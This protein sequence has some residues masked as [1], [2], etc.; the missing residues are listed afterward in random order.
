[1]LTRHCAPVLIA[2]LA[3]TASLTACGGAQSRYES[4]MKR[5]QAYFT[6]GD[7]TKASIEYRNALQVEP[8]SDAARLAVGRTAE[9]LQRPRDAYGLYQ[10][11]IDTSPDNLEAREDMARLLV[12][13]RSPD[14]AVKTLEP[15][16]A[17]HPDDPVLLTLRAAAR[18]Q[19]NNPAGAVADADRALQLAPLNEEA[20]E[21]RSGLY[22]QAGDIAGAKAL[23]ENAVHKLPASGQLREI[24]ADLDLAGNDAAAA[25]QQLTELIKLFPQETRYRFQ[26]AVVYSRNH[27]LDDAQRVLED[28]VKRVSGGDA[29]RSDQAKLALVDFMTAQR[30]PEKGEQTLR[31]FIT[32]DPDN[33]DLRLALGT[34]LQRHGSLP[35][36]IATYNDIVSRAGTKPS[37][38]TARDRL[39]DIAM[40]QDREADA[41]KLIEEVLQKSPHDNDALGQRALIELAHADPAAAIGDL[42]VILRDRPQAVAVQRMLARAYAANGE[43]ALAEQSLRAA[44][45][46]APADAT[47]RTDLAQ[48]LLS[49]D[50]ADEAVR[51]LE[52]V[53]RHAPKDASARTAL[54][55]AYLA[56]QDFDDARKAAE[57]L[58][59][60]RPESG[61][62][63]Y[64]AGLAAV[65]QNKLDDAQKEFEHSLK[66]QP[67]A[68]AP[69]TAFA[70]LYVARGQAPQAIALVKDAATAAPSDPQILNQLGELYVGQKDVAQATD[71]LNRVIALAPKWWVPYRNLAA[72]KL[73]SKDAAG[74]IAAYQAGLKAAPDE[75]QLLGELGLLYENTGRVDDAIALYDAACRRNPHANILANNL[76]ML[77]VT[78]KK[79]R[80]S[81][82]RA[83][84]LTAG[85]A[86]STDGKLLDTNGWVHF[87]RGEYADALPLLGRAADRAPNSKEIRYHLGMAELHA[88][89]TDRARSDLETAVSGSARFFG[90]DEARTTLASLKGKDSTG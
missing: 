15:A 71:T 17:K 5:G 36:A 75:Q 60:L 73:E 7:F 48:L 23:I 68:L 27:Q 61:E 62:G 65:G 22:K 20:I 50:R 39:V 6:Q 58:E 1:M 63:P 85:F 10:S 11:V 28:A 46:V 18:I 83:R 26:L 55:R 9:K 80:A 59:T 70:R 47:L 51:T 4:Y 66:L 69:L 37:G 79:D 56:K 78:Y 43:P 16:F 57:D 54:I 74:A 33:Y 12:Y 8:K 21:V 29:A 42:R 3:A 40:A 86:S 67:R 41:R 88:G 49:T 81:L 87:K 53:V 38:L 64:Y 90:A 32:R 24:L 82:D 2:L 76:A 84:D 13:S 19:L 89:Q 25:E 45:D 34:L 72:V 31:D 44:L 35:Q 52:D 30:S 14:Q 77:L